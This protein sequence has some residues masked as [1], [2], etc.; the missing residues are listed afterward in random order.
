MKLRTT[1]L[2]AGTFSSFDQTQI[3]YEVRGKGDPVIFVYGIACLMNH[4]H[5]QIG[6][7]SKDY[8]TVSFDLRGHHKSATPKDDSNLTL[9][10]LAKDLIALCEH[11]NIKKA[12]FLGHSFGVQVLL[13]AYEL[14]PES[15][16][17]MTFINGFAKNP[18]KGMFGVDVVEQF[19]SLFKQTYGMAPDAWEK[20]WKFAV[21][22]P[23]SIPL[24][25]MAGGFNLSQT[26][27]KDIQIYARGVSALSLDVFSKFFEELMAYDGEGILPKIKVPTLI[28]S[29]EKDGVTPQKYQHHMKSLIPGSEFVSVPYGSHCTQLDF[30]DFVN[31]RIEKFIREVK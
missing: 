26:Q 25:A 11:L 18:I 12:H 10:A 5:H 19:F 13:R 1:E 22:H 8:K 24:T 17:S 9:E 7:F 28:M 27:L 20:V 4:W 6:Y 31:L 14:S 15:F 30:P 3:Y 16:K 29:G 23:I 2:I 21:T